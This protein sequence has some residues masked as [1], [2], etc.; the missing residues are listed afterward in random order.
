MRAGRINRIF[1]AIADPTRREIFHVLVLAGTAMPISQISAHFDMSR[2]GVTK[3]LKVLESAELIE[4]T[5]QGR[6]R[7]CAANPLPLLEVRNWLDT[8]EKFWDDK[9]DELG[10]FLDRKMDT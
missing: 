4:M 10:K 9:L 2:Q 5:P 8:Y 1:K 6:E 7:M 3:H